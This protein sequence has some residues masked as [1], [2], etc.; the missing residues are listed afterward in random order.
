[1][2]I[3]DAIIVGGGPS[4]CAAAY[5]LAAAGLDVLIL[6]KQTFPRFKPCAGALTIKSLKLLRYSIAPVIKKVITT[7]VVK[8]GRY[9]EIILHIDDPIC[10]TAMRSELDEFCLQKTLQKGA[11]FALL[12]GIKKIYENKASVTLTN[13]NG[14]KYYGKYLIGADGVYSEVG[15]I[16]G[17]FSP[18]KTAMALEGIVRLKKCQYNQKLNPKMTFDYGVISQGYG[19]LIPKHDHINVGLYTRRHSKV[20]IS[21]A[22][23]REYTKKRL[24]VG[25]IENM[26]GFPLGTG[27]ENYVPKSS[28]IFLAGDAAGLAEPLWG[29]GIHN[30]IKSGQAAATAVISAVK[31]Q[32]DPNRI[33]QNLI[34]SS[35]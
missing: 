30:A 28:R 34:E 25:D 31:S 21:K 22:K 14:S 6:D 13:I 9:K 12:D 3:Y 10:V 16:T 19:W 29:E 7:K 20:D 18:D 1:M 26:I 33:Y 32:A 11:R 17:Q 15:K 27:G 24:G 4:G 2:K 8:V 23:L 35:Q 5:D